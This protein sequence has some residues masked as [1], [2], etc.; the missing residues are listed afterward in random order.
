[1]NTSPAP[2]FVALHGNRSET[3]LAAVAH[4]L[5]QQPLAPLEAETI[6][7][8]SNGM[9]EWVKM[10]LAQTHGICAAVSLHLPARFQW[11]IYRQVL[12]RE[13]VPARAPLDKT[14]ATWRLMRLLPELDAAPEF[15]PLTAW[16]GERDA[17][18]AFQLARRIADLF[19]QYQVHRPDWLEDWARGS[20]PRRRVVQHFQ[21]ARVQC[22]TD[23]SAAFIA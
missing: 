3:L 21:C 17:L 10:T 22:R 20:F 19:D 18:R 8:Q 13:A 1:M 7:A 5:A 23:G 6:L 9:A 14:A 16:L 4:W 2:G 11:R 12:G 15:A